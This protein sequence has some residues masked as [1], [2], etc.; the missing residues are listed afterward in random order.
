M[1]QF[2][3]MQAFV[4]IVEAGS[5]T[6]AAEQMNTVKSSVSRRL[7]ELEKRLGVTLIVRT[8][9]N[10]TLTENGQSYYQQ[11]LRII[12]DV[13]EIESNMSSDHQALKGKIRVSA[14]LS[15]GLAHLAPALREFN[16]LHPDIF[17]DVDFNDRKVDLVEEGFDLAIRISNLADSTLMARKITQIS[18]VLCASS[19]YIEKYSLP[20]TPLDLKR[21]HVKV[22]YCEAAE[23]WSFKLHS[24]KELNVKVPTVLT[25]NNG[26]FLCQAAID[27]LGLIFTPDF[28]VYKAIK[29]GQLRPIL[30]E[31]Y[32][33][34]D[35]PAY[36]VYP[37]NKHLSQRVRALID[38]LVD[39]YG[40]QPYWQLPKS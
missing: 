5:I 3:D 28:I 36:A 31:F 6:K 10:Q 7:S 23:N 27:G 33:N 34:I 19:A 22:N 30:S 20:I 2:E 21:G 12:D 29:N 18:L 32:D 37:Q 9:R 1:N 14:P 13:A 38:F 17:F 24:Q 15:F 16:H 35:I 40:D 8:T 25:S 39:Y 26:D 4:R 11:C